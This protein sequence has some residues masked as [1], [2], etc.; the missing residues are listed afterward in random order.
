MIE[1]N[2]A[3][4][5]KQELIKAQRI[6]D[7]VTVGSIIIGIA[8]IVVV[9]LLASYVFVAQS[10]R[11]MAAD[12][13]ISK[14]SESL[15]EIKD[16]SKTLTIQNQLTKISDIYDSKKINSRLFNLLT[17]IIPPEPNDIKYSSL[18]IDSTLGIISIEGQA[19]NSYA[20]LET[21][22]KTI[23]GATVNYT[24]SVGEVQ[25]VPLTAGDIDISST[26][27]GEDSTTSNMV[28]RF[29]FSFAYSP[30]LFA[31]TSNKLT[32]SISSSGNVTDSYLGVP[33]SI[34]TSRANDIVEGDQ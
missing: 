26:S 14:Q 5:V 23:K 4:D 33:R 17:T 30:E 10:V 27:Y 1:I 16:L 15:T 12:S 11:N 29:A 24:D 2:L 9:A 6:R 18:K 25:S 3:P 13:E 8:S 21:F 31:V 22:I 20:A 28:L 32:V 7:K 34:F 19:V